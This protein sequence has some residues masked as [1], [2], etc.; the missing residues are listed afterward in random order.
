MEIKRI[1]PK[2]AENLIRE[3]DEYQ[4]KLYP[5]DSCHLDS[6]E[7]LQSENAYFYGA[8]ENDEIIAIGSV[9]IFAKYGELKRIYVPPS[10]RGKG[11]AQKI[12]KELESLLIKK[13]IFLAKLETGPYSKDAIGLYKKLGYSISGKF[14]NYKEDPLSTFMEKRLSETDKTIF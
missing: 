2:Q 1:D 14:G 10:Q 9:K 7:T 13:K 6:I 4:S 11:L 5:P 12:I 8:F 3:L